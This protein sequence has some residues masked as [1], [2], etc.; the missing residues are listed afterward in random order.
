M[1]I[2]QKINKF[3]QPLVKQY[4]NETLAH[5]KGIRG[6]INTVNP[7]YQ[8][9]E[10]DDKT[11]YNTQEKCSFCDQF[12]TR[13]EIYYYIDVYFD[14]SETILTYP[15]EGNR[16]K[17]PV[18]YE[19][20]GLKHLVCMDCTQIIRNKIQKMYQEQNDYVMLDSEKPK[21]FDIP[22]NAKIPENPYLKIFVW[23]L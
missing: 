8:N 9:S 15:F 11:W 12:Y 2:E 5:S 6:C 22:K 18:M 3:L 4:Q 14:M 16:N 17:I 21:N 23:M 19:T 1:S 13:K 7:L 20:K 10:Q